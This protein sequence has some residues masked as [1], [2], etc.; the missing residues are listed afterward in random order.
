MA[1]NKS[2]SSALI[3][4]PNAFETYT[5]YELAELAKCMD[6][7]TGV[8]HFAENYA[9]I[10][11][12]VHGKLKF[13]PYEYQKRVLADFNK[14]EHVITMQPRQSGKCVNYQTRIKVR[15]KYTNQVIET[16]IGDFFEMTKK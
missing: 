9:H 5:E 8:L 3:K 2:L 13:K 1:I 7:D 15:N 11:H 4:S 12:P 16:T 10:Q 6:P 14:H